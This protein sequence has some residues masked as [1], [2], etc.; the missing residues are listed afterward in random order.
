M[1]PPV[2]AALPVV[3]FP[4]TVATTCLFVGSTMIISLLSNFANSLPFSEETSFVTLLGS[5]WRVKD[6][7]TV[8]EP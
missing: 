3:L 1:A 4:L 8:A 6:C 7:G 2:D 5:W